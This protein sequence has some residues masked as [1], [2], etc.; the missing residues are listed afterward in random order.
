MT[1]HKCVEPGYHKSAL[2]VNAELRRKGYFVPSLMQT[3]RVLVAYERLGLTK[4]KE[5]R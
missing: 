5:H 2:A 4:K 3:E 1:N